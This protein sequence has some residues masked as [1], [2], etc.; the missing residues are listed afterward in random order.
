[1]PIV[2][3]AGGQEIYVST[4]VA[5]LNKEIQLAGGKLGKERLR[6]YCSTANSTYSAASAIAADPDF[7]EE[8]VGLFSEVVVKWEHGWELG[9]VEKMVRL[10]PKKGC[11]K[12]GAGRQEYTQPVS[13]EHPPPN[14]ELQI[15]WLRPVSGDLLRFTNNKVDIKPIEL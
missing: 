14:L 11:G 12:K 3:G 6:R 1:V 4:L 13:L 15:S 10:F 7:G 5:R 2:N 8:T 9:I